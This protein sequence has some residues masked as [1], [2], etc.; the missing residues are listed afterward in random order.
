MPRKRDQFV[1]SGLSI[2]QRTL[3]LLVRRRPARGREGD[4][5]DV[6]Q[7]LPHD[8]LAT[9]LALMLAPCFV[10]LYR[11]LDLAQG[12]PFSV[13]SPIVR[14]L[15]K[16]RHER[17]RP[18]PLLGRRT[19]RG[20]GRWGFRPRA[21]TDDQQLLLLVRRLGEDGTS[22]GLDLSWRGLDLVG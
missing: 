12:F 3:V 8:H 17:P 13:C 10:D 20:P 15:V 4:H 16:Q 21:A 22:Q 11:K 19:L 18:G 7:V 1:P 9:T 2:R 6:L 14:P 5:E